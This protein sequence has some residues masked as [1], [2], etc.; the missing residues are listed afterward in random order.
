MAGEC[1]CS[2]LCPAVVGLVPG[3]VVGLQG[4]L[5]VMALPW[6]GHVPSAAGTEFPAC[7]PSGQGE[8]TGSHDAQCAK[9]SCITWIWGSGFFL[10]PNCESL[11]SGTHF[12]PFRKT[13]RFGNMATARKVA[14]HLGAGRMFRALQVPST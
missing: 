11:L 3:G 2:D 7:L 4:Q 8:Q 10:L 5:S 12:M 13:L 14:C 6:E 1:P 9:W